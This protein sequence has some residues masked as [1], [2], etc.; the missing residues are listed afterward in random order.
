MNPNL[1]HRRAISRRQFST[2]RI[3][4]W[5]GCARQ[6]AG[7]GWSLQGGGRRRRSGRA[8]GVGWR[9]VAPGARQIRDLP[10]HVG[11]AAALDLF[12]WKPK[13]TEL[14]VQAVSRSHCWPGKRFAFIKGLPK[15]LGSPYR[16]AAAGRSRRAG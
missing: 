12:D 11:G 7:S 6:L 14:D 15:L 2:H 1:L 8:A 5:R 16:F 13:L 9:L 10:P 3:Q 4:F